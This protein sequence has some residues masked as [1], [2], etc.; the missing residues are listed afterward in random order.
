MNDFLNRI[1]NAV[2]EGDDEAAEI[3][4][5]KALDA[6]L[7]AATVL[8]DGLMKGMDEVGIRFR[9]GDMFI[10]EVLL[11]AKA[12][13]CGNDILKPLLANQESAHRGR[14]VLGTVAGDLHD[15][16]K[17][18]VGMMLEGAGYEVI[19]L[20]IDVTSSQFIQAAKDNNADAI[21]MSA[22]LT[23]TMPVMAEVTRAIAEENLGDKIKIMIGGAPVSDIYAQKIGAN[24]SHDAASAVELANTLLG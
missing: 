20:G 17:K 11:S 4:V 9:D 2:L 1:A 10:P 23:T 5:T 24:Y 15:I 12:M 14:I 7:D 16:G 18:L 22:M 3:L 19:D 6:G 8:N 13:Q 21:G